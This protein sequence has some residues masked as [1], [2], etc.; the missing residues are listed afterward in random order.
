MITEADKAWLAGIFDAKARMFFSQYSKMPGRQWARL[1]LYSKDINM[2]SEVKTLLGKGGQKISVKGGY[3]RRPCNDHCPE[4]HVHVK[5]QTQHQ[6]DF[7]G[8]HAI[9]VMHNV[10]P[11]MRVKSGEAYDWMQTALLQPPAKVGIAY[12]IKVCDFMRKSGWCVPA[13][14]WANMDSDAIRLRSEGKTYQQM[15]DFWGIS[16][17]AARARYRSAV[18]RESE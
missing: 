13:F 16:K 6:V 7:S 4:K 5:F 11:F 14:D 17:E 18:G 12:G 10:M 1:C 2:V 8:V 15:A 9:I 3:D